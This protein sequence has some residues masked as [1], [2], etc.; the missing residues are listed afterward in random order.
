MDRLLPKPLRQERTIRIDAV[1]T[2]TC[3]DCLFAAE[4]LQVF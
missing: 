2:E 4:N 3:P 1:E